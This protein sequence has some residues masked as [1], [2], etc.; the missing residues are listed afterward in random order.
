[1]TRFEPLR[2]RPRVNM[3]FILFAHGEIQKATGN[4]KKQTLKER[5]IR[6]RQNRLKTKIRNF[7]SELYKKMSLKMTFGQHP[8]SSHSLLPKN[9]PLLTKNKDVKHKI[10]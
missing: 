7:S 9:Y 4:W 2:A 3:C 5:N 6:N 8:S 10:T 1:M